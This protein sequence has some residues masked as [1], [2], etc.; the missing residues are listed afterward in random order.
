MEI[1]QKNMIF[2][3]AL[4]A[5]SIVSFLAMDMYLPALP[6]LAKELNL[7][8]DMA[9]YS[10][11]VWLLGSASFQ[12]LIGPLSDYYGRKLFFV[13]GIIVFFISSLVIAFTKDY[14]TILIA[15]F[16]QGTTVCSTMV[17]GL[18][19][20][21]HVFSGKVAVQVI[22]ILMTITVVAPALG[23]AIGA[24]IVKYY[25]WQD[26]FLV[27]ATAAFISF[28]INIYFMPNTSHEGACLSVPKIV[29]NYY[30]ILSNSSFMLFIFVNCFLTSAF[31]MWIVES[32]FIIIS[33]LGRGEIYYGL[34]QI[35]IFGAFVVGGQVTRY[36]INYFSVERVV[37]AGMKVALLGSTLFLLVSY[38]V[39]PDPYWVCSMTLLSLGASMTFGAL[40]RYIVVSSNSPMGSK[41]AISST[42][43]SIIGVISTIVVSFLNNMT[44]FNIAVPIFVVTIAAVGVFFCMTLPDI[45]SI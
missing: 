45:D 24:F 10:V 18:A 6:T 43:T 27:L 13:S 41:V 21:H 22:S 11:T 37:K 35:P 19:T 38:F 34:I 17:A 16:F 9:Q 12:L 29:S 1:K 26:I 25:N 15:R 30:K 3:I 33:G 20:I 2:A 40:N 32:P 23:P 14:N 7:S 31:F 36:F 5:F 42:S 4:T 28:P 44:F 8:N 39:L